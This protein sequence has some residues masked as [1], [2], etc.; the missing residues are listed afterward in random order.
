LG[1]AWKKV[2]LL[3]SALP[4][5]VA[6]SKCDL[7]GGFPASAFFCVRSGTEHASSI[8]ACQAFIVYRIIVLIYNDFL[9]TILPSDGAI[10]RK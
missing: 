10:T 6:A 9:S 1:H 8:K 5:V 2:T 4:F 7:R 3:Q